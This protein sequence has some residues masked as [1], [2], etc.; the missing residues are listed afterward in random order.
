MCLF[1]FGLYFG[2]KVSCLVSGNGIGVVVF[3]GS[4]LDVMKEPSSEPW[5]H[6]TRITNNQYQELLFY[7]DCNIQMEDSRNIIVDDSYVEGTFDQYLVQCPDMKASR[8][9]KYNIWSINSSEESV[10]PIPERFY[11]SCLN[12][13]GDQIGYKIDPIWNLEP[14]PEIN[15]DNDEVAYYAAVDYAITEYTTSAINLFKQ[16]ISQF[17][18]SEYAPASANNLLALEQDKLALK[19]YYHNEPNMHWNGEIDKLA[20]YLENYCNIQMGNYQEAIAWFEAIISDPPSELDSLMAV[21][22]LGYTYLLMQENPPKAPV[23]CMYPQLKPKSRLEFNAK[24]D[25]ILSGIYHIGNQEPDETYN[26]Y[27]DSPVPVLDKNY[28][29]PFNPS[30]ALAFTLPKETKVK[31]DVYNLKGQK[32]KTLINGT[33]TKGKHSVV[34][35]GTDDRGRPVSSGMYFY[36]LVTPKAVLTNKM[37]LMK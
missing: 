37:I 9:F 6:D 30:T 16:I 32:I 36:K 27:I 10:M 28:P 2:G 7:D 15:P 23:T 12:P 14:I 20:D 33:Q 1:D 4:N 17:P 19:N 29:N 18:E 3:R 35:N 21:I 8:Y 5:F 11:P 34:W 31:L 24:R 25:A 13:E 26:F 22:D